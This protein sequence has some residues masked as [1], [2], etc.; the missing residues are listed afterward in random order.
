[1][2][3]YIKMSGTKNCIICGKPAIM[4]TGHIHTEMGTIAAGHCEE[5]HYS[6]GTGQI[7]GCDSPNPNSCYGKRVLSDVELN[8]PLEEE[9]FATV[10]GELKIINRSEF[11]KTDEANINKKKSVF[12]I[13]F[14]L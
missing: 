14:G 12:A 9:Y 6:N 11:Y 2:I 4:W 7:T 5:H 8:E 10:N 3:K 1:M 13:L